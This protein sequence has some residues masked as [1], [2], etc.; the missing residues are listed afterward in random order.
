MTKKVGARTKGNRKSLARPFILGFI[1]VLL[2]AGIF[3]AGMQFG[4]GVW[5]FGI[6]EPVTANQ[7]L[8]NRL[9]YSSV[10]EVY[11]AL[12]RKYDG[13][14]DEQKLMTGLKKGL[15]E[16][17]GDP[18]TTYFDVDEAKAFN[19]QLNGSF[20]GIGAE[21]AKDGSAIVVVSPIAGFPAEKAGLKSKDVIIAIDGQDAT[22]LSVEEAVKRIRGESGTS[23]K[24][25]IVRNSTETQDLTIQ[26]QVIT[27]PS[28][29]SKIIDGNIGYIRITRFAEDTPKLVNQAAAE[30]KTK[31]VKGI[32]LD[33]RGNPGGY[34]TGAVDI[35]GLWLKQGQ[36]ILEEKRDGKVIKDYKADTTGALQG[37]PTVVLINEGSASASEITAGALKDNNAAQIVGVTSYGKG[38][39]QEFSTF[40]SGSVLKVTVARW[41]TPAGKNIDKEGITPTVKVELSEADAK[42]SNDTQ[43]KRAQELLK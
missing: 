35:S 38:S 5:T 20:S 41:F 40:G 3:T 1:G 15:V 25:T 24:L 8:P 29:E 4:K 42:A 26:R 7:G 10:N 31:G 17:A 36:I 16:A 14:L 23:V 33:M 32:I 22:G 2:I 19:E 34:L 21:L 27:I 30:F 18:Y 39:V 9:D 13:K 28:V 43:L 37:M 12:V 11:E 6:K